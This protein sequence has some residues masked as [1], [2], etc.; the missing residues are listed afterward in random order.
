M[1]IRLAARQLLFGYVAVMALLAALANGDA[2]AVS[3]LKYPL[4]IAALLIF[5]RS[6]GDGRDLRDS[7][8]ALVPA[9]GLAMFAWFL[10]ITPDAA[11]PPLT[12]QLRLLPVLYLAGDLLVVLTLARRSR[13]AR[14]AARPPRC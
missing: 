5:I 14:C 9:V 13:P 6:R 2:G 11:S 1:G 7:A 12:W 8:G 4:I 3:V 10:L